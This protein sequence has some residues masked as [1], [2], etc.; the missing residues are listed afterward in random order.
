ML[1]AVETPR[2]HD[3]CV[4]EEFLIRAAKLT[5]ADAIAD[6]WLA[7]FRETYDFPPAHTD[8]EVRG[9]VRRGLLPSTETW[10]ASRD[11]IVVGFMALRGERV[12]QLYVRR[13]WTGRGLGSRLLA[14]ARDACPDGL[15][16]WTFQVNAAA[17]R[18]YERH[19]FRV[20]EQ[21]DGSGNEE[22]QPDVRYVW[23]PRS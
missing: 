9:W 13:P 1:H 17:R 15:E 18:F 10:V 7:A 16:L 2:R 21:T 22:R 6:T 14:R 3:R 5:D 23:S 20:A 4:A 19:G 11:G 12:E 8:D